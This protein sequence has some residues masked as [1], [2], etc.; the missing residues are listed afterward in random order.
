MAET[1]TSKTAVPHPRTDGV[2]GHG[3][4]GESDVRLLGFW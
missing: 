4:G 3:N 1:G 2:L